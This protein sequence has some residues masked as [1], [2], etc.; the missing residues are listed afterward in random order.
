MAYAL[1]V[2]YVTAIAKIDPWI[3]VWY[4]TYIVYMAFQMFR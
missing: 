3:Y 2:Q 4:G 1:S